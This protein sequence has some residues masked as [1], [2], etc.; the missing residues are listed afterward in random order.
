MVER[1][2]KG[3]WLVGGRDCRGRGDVGGGWT[4]GRGWTIGGG[5][6]CRR[7]EG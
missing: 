5:G 7:W 6:S 1:V 4:I 3:N 2:C